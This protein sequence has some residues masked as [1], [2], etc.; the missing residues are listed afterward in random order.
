MR[1]VY[2]FWGLVPALF[3]FLVTQELV[4]R[5]TGMHGKEDIKG[6]FTQFFYTG[7]ALGFSILCDIYVFFDLAQIFMLGE[8]ETKIISWLQYP[9]VLL[10]MLQM[11]R[12]MDKRKD[13]GGSKAKGTASFTR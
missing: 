10:I 8:E 3:L 4:R 12:F 7:V 9:I 5:A 1:I 6:Y 13:H 11:S 2:L